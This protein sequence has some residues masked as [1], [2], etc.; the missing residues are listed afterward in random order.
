MKVLSARYF[1]S[2]IILMIHI[3]ITEVKAQGYML[4][5][6]STVPNELTVCGVSKSFG[7]SLYNPSPNLLTN[8]TVTVNMPAGMR[9]DAG[10]IIGATELNITNLSAPQFSIADINTLTS[11]DISYTASPGCDISDYL[12]AGNAAQNNI[13]I[14]YFANGNPTFDLHT[15]FTYLVKQPNLSITSVTNQSYSGNVGDVFTRCIT[16][17][18]GGL[19]ELRG[20]TLSDI[21]G[22]GI[23]ITATDKGVLSTQGNTSNITINTSDLTSVGNGNQLFESGEQITICETVSVLSCIEVSSQL[24]A[25][26]GCGN[27]TCQFSAS[28]ANVVFPN[29]TPNIVVTDQPT[30]QACY[31]MNQPNPQQLT[32]SNTGA[33][34]AINVEIEIY[35]STGSAFVTNMSSAIDP[36]SFSLQIG[37]GAITPITAIVL[38]NTANYAC[39]GGLRP[40]RVVITIPVI[41]GGTTAYL[42]WNTYSCCHDYCGGTS[43]HAGTNNGWSYK[44]QYNSICQNNYVIPATYARAYSQLYADLT[45]NNSP[46]TIVAGQTLTYSLMFSNDINGY[47]STAGRQWRFVVTVPN[48]LTFSGN[49][50]IVANNG[51]SIWNPTAVVTTGNTA[52]ITFTGNQP[53]NRINGDFR[54]DLTANCNNCPGGGGLINV[55]SYFISDPN[56]ACTH[57]ISCIDI[58]TNVV[59]PVQ[60]SGINNTGFSV[61]RTSYG[62]RDDNNDGV[63]ETGS[64]SLNLIRR[65]RAMFGD[66]ITTTFNGTV[67]GGSFPFIYA[68][69]RITNGNNYL[70]FLDGLFTINR[71][72]TI[73]NCNVSTA[74]VTN[75]GNV[76]TFLFDLSAV[77]LITTGCVPPGFNFQNGD[78]LQFSPRYKVIRNTGGGILNCEVTNEFYASNIANP[79]N[80]NEKLYCNNYTGSFSIIGYYYTNWGPNSFST[81]SCND[82]T[83]SQNYYLSIG[84]CC[85]QYAGGNL[86]PYEY[87]SWAWAQ[88]LSVTV[89]DGYSF[90]SAQFN[91]TR[92]AG[93][94]AIQTT[95]W[96]PLTPAVVNGN[97]MVFEVE[98]YFSRQGGAFMESDDGFYGTLQLTLRPSCAVVPSITSPLIYDWTFGESAQL[99]GS[100][101]ANSV[102][103]STHDFITYQGPK[104]F[105]QSQLPSILAQD[106]TAFWNVSLSNITSVTAHNVWVSGPQVSGVS[107][108][109]VFDIT[110]GTIITPTAGGIYELGQLTANAQRDLRITAVYTSCAT[111]SIIIHSGWNCDTYPSDI[112]TYPC[113]T[114]KIKLTLSPQIPTLIAQVNSPP[115]TINLCDTASYSV[116]GIN[117]QLGTAYDLKLRI[118]LPPGVSIISGSAVLSYPPGAPFNSIPDPVLISGTTYEWDISTLNATLGIDGLKGILQTTLNS[119]KIN[120]GVRTNCDYTSGSLI[121]F[122]F[123][124]RSA[125]GLY[126]GQE[127]TLSSQLNITG[128]DKPYETDIALISSYISPCVNSTSMTVKI[129]NN[130]PLSTGPSDSV[131][132]V[133]PENI[134]YINGSF[135]GVLNSP[136]PTSFRTYLLNNKLHCV[137][138]LPPNVP[139]GDSIIFSFQFEASP[140]ALSCNIQ[141]FE[142]YTTSAKNLLC[143]L[144]GIQCDVNVKTGD[145]ILPMYVYKGNLSFTNINVSATQNGT[146]GEILQINTDLLNIGEDIAQGYETV[147]SFYYDSNGN[148][149]W[150]NTDILLRRDTISQQIDNSTT[151]TYITTLNVAPGQGCNLIAVLDTVNNGCI[152]NASFIFTDDIPLLNAGTDVDFCSG[153]TVSIGG[154]PVNGYQYSWNPTQGLQNASNYNASLSLINNSGNNTVIPYILTTNRVNC[155]SNDT[156]LVTVYPETNVSFSGLAASYCTNDTNAVL[157]GNPLGGIFSGNG[158]NGNNFSPAISQAGSQNIIY[159]YTD[160][161]N[162]TYTDTQQTIVYTSPSASFTGLNTEYCADAN[163]VTLTGQPLGGTF[164]GT[165]I[166]GNNFDPQI[167][168][169][170]NHNIIYEFIDVNQ[171]N[172]I[173]TQ[174]VTIH[175]LPIVSFLGLAPEYCINYPNASLTGTPPGGVFSGN[176]IVSNNF[177][178]AVAAQGTYNIIYSYIDSNQ[179]FAADTQIVVVHP[180]TPV[181]FSGLDVAYCED[182]PSVIMTG[183]PAGGAFA[184]SGVNANSFSPSLAG[185]G[186]HALTYSYTD[187]NN[188]FNADTQTVIINPLPVVNFSGLNSA[189]CVD[190]GVI[191]L[192]GNSPGGV[193]S[194][195]GIAG[196]SFIPA[197]AGAGSHTITYSYTDTNNCF[198][199][200]SQLTIVRDLP[201]VSFTGLNSEYC[202]NDSNSVLLGSPAGG[203]FSGIGIASNVFIPTNTN[204]G[205][206]TITYTYTD[207]NNCTNTSTHSIVVH[208]APDVQALLQHVL[209]YA[210]NNGS[211]TLSV[212]QGTSPINYIWNNGEYTSQNINSLSPGN[213]EL[214]VTDAVGCVFIET[215]AIIEPDSLR[216]NV[217]TEDAICFADANGSAVVSVS[218]GIPPYNYLWNNGNNVSEA[219]NLVAD[220][221]SITITDANGCTNEHQ[222][223]INENEPLVLNVFPEIDSVAFGNEITITTE[224]YSEKL[225]AT[226]IWE[227]E[228]GLSCNNCSNPTASPLE[229]TLYTVNMTDADGCSTTDEILVIVKDKKVFYAPNIFSPN[230]DG[231]N[232]SF[233]I[234]VKGEKRFYLRIYDRWGEKVFESEDA[235]ISW[236]GTMN[237]KKLP[238]GV[239]VYEV[240]LIFKDNV[241]LKHKGSITLVR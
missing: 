154:Q 176:G 101:T 81:S 53:F 42:R 64:P 172:D 202:T 92:T 141:E 23:L 235:S 63:P 198:N 137:W 83:V 197:V 216:S 13:F 203:I 103:V 222:F 130:G 155:T 40:G 131:I 28:S 79:V 18:N 122:N 209:C 133:F 46:A 215:Y 91:H 17:T 115:N 229:T 75:A 35:Q 52:T 20:F 61:F 161:N 9:Y 48:C 204:E 50:R 80:A 67:S 127:I 47:T 57:S 153:D 185:A 193:F 99:Q 60:C 236:D 26:W 112:V 43:P 32:I 234:F 187:S 129:A 19:G 206:H 212:S 36:N 207:T 126:T 31:G 30:Q 188:C 177:S 128:A 183:I 94:Q 189:Y 93:N 218:G 167:A 158:I 211:I 59:C 135:V 200:D 11:L 196:S 37:G 233:Q 39:L 156:M 49:A 171:C 152:C 140:F 1:F 228:T 44:G 100:N 241:P 191:I 186:T 55:A 21:H 76:R 194:G 138:Q 90:V 168:G 114:E 142:S 15:T 220:S 146:S 166:S 139:A 230:N 180:L 178:P 12:A 162:C 78:I 223:L 102:V 6:N 106:N 62:Q 214:T 164:Y 77:S 121:G 10:S 25:S 86:F 226:F 73:Y 239:Y 109:E 174:N 45:N 33:G 195:S 192:N 227:P 179:C 132:V 238:E 145:T 163:I 157:F 159:Y 2:V 58:P 221:Y 97:V 54:F 14:E 29:L 56:C 3:S 96:Q 120:F 201:V 24:N 151:Y 170:G 213:Y 116:E 69:S 70:N 160:A 118:V 125:C 104:L 87:R 208:P 175:P 149:V 8:V 51:V 232:D 240:H 105:V 181:S 225:P 237:N 143:I 66:T 89:P 136:L 82:I 34:Q 68:Q 148:G 190:A 173:D 111:D 165:G 7:I 199:A 169:I 108:I 74:T 16:V 144:N 88:T 147:I 65:D 231:I 5:I 84:P 124:G 123:N 205:A 134:N 117:I 4:A 110:N 184:G 224:Y 119:V 85:Q 182:A 107:I 219:Y 95:A 217:V 150:N 71:G 113:A 38:G 41:D 22:N 98:Q 27:Q 72:G 210:D